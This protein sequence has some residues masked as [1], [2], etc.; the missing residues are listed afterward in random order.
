MA[1]HPGTGAVIERLKTAKT[2]DSRDLLDALQFSR[3]YGGF[4]EQFVNAGGV[5]RVFEAI[6]SSH[7]EVV[8]VLGLWTLSTV[9]HTQ[10]DLV[11]QLG[12]AHDVVKTVRHAVDEHQVWIQ[13]PAEPGARV[14]VPL[15]TT[16][17]EDFGLDVLFAL[18]PLQPEGLL[19][20]ALQCI[21][22]AL[23]KMETVNGPLSDAKLR[24]LMGHVRQLAADSRE[25][26][27]LLMEIVA[28]PR[29]ARVLSKLPPESVAENTENLAKLVRLGL[30]RVV[31]SSGCLDAVFDATASVP[32]IQVLCLDLCLELNAAGFRTA[33]L[34]HSPALAQVLAN[35]ANEYGFTEANVNERAIL[36]GEEH[37]VDRIVAQAMRRF[38][39]GLL[40][41]DSRYE[42]P[43][44]P[45]PAVTSR[46]VS[47]AGGGRGRRRSRSRRRTTKSRTPSRRRL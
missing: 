34:R 37:V 26:D 9:L 11:K 7:D 47:L 30:G 36:P 43:W 46:D 8:H 38:S 5:A 19:K 23:R 25:A 20:T 21:S 22:T 13:Q 45:A 12:N 27:L 4:A 3:R 32:E 10:G 2:L 33:V 40:I 1:S 15:S 14:T 35:M 42:Q 39:P 6:T 18:S 44:H 31:I 24:H 17:I 28:L 16:Q 41:F 29:L